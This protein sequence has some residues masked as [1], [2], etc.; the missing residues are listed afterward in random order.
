MSEERVN[1]SKELLDGLS[2]SVQELTGTTEPMSIQ[3]MSTAVN[4]KVNEGFEL[5]ETIVLI[6][7]VSSVER[8]KEPN[9]TAYN[10]KELYVE[11]TF[12]NRTK[13]EKAAVLYALGVILKLYSQ[14]VYGVR[15][16]IVQM[17]VGTGQPENHIANARFYLQL[18]NRMFKNSCTYGNTGEYSSRG[19]FIDSN[20]YISSAKAITGF[21]V[22]CS[23]SVFPVVATPTIKIYGIRA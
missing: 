19:G 21:R 8:T 10:F 5:I 15:P 9:G 18:R 16:Y 1:V 12:P 14:W 2:D 6:E 22:S 4:A 11:M 7:E 3:E 13:L 20:M 17:N 23:N